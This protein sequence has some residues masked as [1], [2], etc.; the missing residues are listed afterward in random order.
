MILSIIVAVLL[1]LGAVYG[2]Q[3]GLVL[4]LVRLISVGLSWI[5]AILTCAPVTTFIYTI[6]QNQQTTGQT[7]PRVMTIIIFAILF[8]LVN[9][10]LWRLGRTLNLVTKLP[11]IHLLNGLLGAVVGLIIRY[12]IIFIA[13]NI[14]ILIP[15][16]WVQSQYQA[17]QL[18][19]TIVTKTPVIS[20][21]LLHQWQN[22]LKH[23]N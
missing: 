9:T 18:S 14:F 6:G 12:L 23:Q 11:V 13:L 17:S 5:A 8:F 19:Q 3:T 15:N 22:S 2:Y 20:Q 7:P 1:A 4:Q 10:L 21:Q 16:D